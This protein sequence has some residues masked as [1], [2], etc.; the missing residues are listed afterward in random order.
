MIM[1][2]RE[3]ENLVRW[4]KAGKNRKPEKLAVTLENFMNSINIQQ[5]KLGSVIELWDNILPVNLKKHCKLADSKGGKL[6]VIVDSPS[7]RMELNWCADEL[8][9]EINKHCPSARIKEI[10]TVIGKI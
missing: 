10:R 4:K 6:K 9:E 7:H 2:D 8:I 5:K 1:E 3:F